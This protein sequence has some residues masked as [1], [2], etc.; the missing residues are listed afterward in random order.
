MKMSITRALAE[1]KRI[2][3]KL[4]SSRNSTFV[5]V[6]LGRDSNKRSANASHTLAELTSRIQSSV[7]TQKELFRKR[8]VLKAAIVLSNASTKVNI[9][10]RTITV[11][12][13]IEL[14]RSVQLKEQ[15]SF[16][17]KSQIVATS[18]HV[19]ELNLKLNTEIESNLTAI[20]GSDK[21]KVDA[22]SYD[23]VSKP[24]L[25]MREASLFDPMDV[26]KYVTELDE[27]ISQIN[28]ELDFVL[29][30]SNARTEIEV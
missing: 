16:F 6:T 19:E 25:A 24:K 22:Q 11:A 1:L 12:E 27:E 20:Y 18:K 9:A 7:D 4:E 26:A 29:S 5:A 14:K 17:I 15:L 13:A 30:E 21:N 2:D 10:G 3:D 23:M 8:E 28:T